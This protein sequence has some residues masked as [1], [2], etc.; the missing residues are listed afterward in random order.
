MLEFAKRPIDDRLVYFDEV[1]SRRGLRRLIVE[2]DFWVCFILRLL[3]EIPDLAGIFIFKG[4]TSLSKVFNIIM[5]FSE[6]IDL[7]VDPGWLGIDHDN[8]PDASQSR[9]QNDK[10]MER[11]N[12]TC[13]EA[14]KEQIQPNLERAICEVLGSPESCEHHLSFSIEKRSPVLLFHYPTKEI[15]LQGYVQ[16]QVKLELGSLTDQEPSGIHTATSWVAEEFPDEFKEPEFNVISLE[17]ERTFWEKATILHAEFHRPPEKPMRPHLSRDIYDLCKIAAHESGQNALADLNLFKRV[18]KFKKVCFY[19][20]WANYDEAK[21]G[22]FHLLPP[23]HRLAG[24]KTD[25][26]LMQQEMIFE[27]S[28]DFDELL[29]QLRTIEKKINSS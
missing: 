3:F 6:D 25:F 9:T 15:S 2:K 10:R 16:P 21:P 19:N 11:L 14:V 17:P 24:V 12:A 7:S 27:D 4:G 5:R 8:L 29:E 22:T 23:E 18:V 13:C 28:P 20:T 26:K 1:A